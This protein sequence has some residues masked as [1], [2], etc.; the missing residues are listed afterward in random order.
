MNN[1]R[2]NHIKLAGS[3]ALLGAVASNARWLKPLG[4]LLG[5]WPLSH[6]AHANN[7]PN[8]LLPST[9]LVYDL[10]GVQKGLR[11][12]ATATLRWQRNNS[13]YVAALS[14][15]ILVVFKRNQTSQGRIVD[16]TLQPSLFVD[17][18][19]RIRQA[20][21]NAHERRID[22]TESGPAPYTPDTQDRLSIYFTLPALMAQARQRQR[23][24]F[25]VPVSS[26]NS[27]TQWDFNMGPR[28]VIDTPM[29]QWSAQTLSRVRQTADD[30]SATL[31]YGGADEL[32]PLRIRLEDSDGTWLEQNL[33]SHTRID[34]LA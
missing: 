18:G 8:L 26:A 5:T 29:G 23:N 7:A 13:S 1:S 21:F 2:R 24:T 22:Y 12:N 14:A 31:W 4:A 17:Q 20:N 11:Y 6:A 9:A 34:D 30:T 25:S 33:R 10:T 27:L 19:K 15:R 16:Q 3:S 28:E 32:L